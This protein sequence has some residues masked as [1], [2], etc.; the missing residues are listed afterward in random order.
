[1]SNRPHIT[2]LPGA[3]AERRRSFLVG[4]LRA[5]LPTGVETNHGSWLAASGIAKR[6]MAVPPFSR[7]RWTRD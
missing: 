7:Q 5:A 2:R 1:M 6:L 3:D 4:Y